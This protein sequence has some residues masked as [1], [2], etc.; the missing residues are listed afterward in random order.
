MKKIFSFLAIATVAATMFTSCK[1]NETPGTGPDVPKTAKLSLKV[2]KEILKAGEKGEFYI[3]SDIAVSEDVVIDVKSGD[4]AILTVDPASVTIAKDKKTISGN[5][6]AIADGKTTITIATTSKVVSM[7]KSSADVTVG[8][9]GAEVVKMFTGFHEAENDEDQ[10]YFYAYHED[11]TDPEPEGQRAN[12]AYFRISD[13][14]TEGG[15]IVVDVYAW[16]S[17]EQA[18]GVGVL[19]PVDDKGEGIFLTP[20]AEGTAITFDAMATSPYGFYETLCRPDYKDLATGQDLYI[21]IACGNGAK[22]G[23]SSTYRAWAKINIGTAGGYSDV[24][25]IEA[26]VC[27]NDGEFKVGQKS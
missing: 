2:E 24:T 7:V 23:T 16:S 5:Y 9:P 10:T 6:T 18:M 8:A 21:V 1:K 11:P 12:L 17:A 13:R 14:G 15:G 25:F 20:V 3:T 22:E 19:K 26:Y 27:L 4:V